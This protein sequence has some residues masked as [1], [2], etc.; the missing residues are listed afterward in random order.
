[1]ADLELALVGSDAASAVHCT[2]V[3]V[4]KLPADALDTYSRDTYISPPQDSPLMLTADDT[5]NTQLS[6]DYHWFSSTSSSD[7]L[8]WLGMFHEMQSR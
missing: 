2:V 1:M 4:L 8:M 3:T 7:W 6:D 5:C